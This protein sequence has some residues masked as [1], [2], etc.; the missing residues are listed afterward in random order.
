MKGDINMYIKKGCIVCL[1]FLCFGFSSS[2]DIEIPEH[3]ASYVANVSEAH[4]KIK[5]ASIDTASYKQQPSSL[6]VYFDTLNYMYENSSKSSPQN[7]L[8]KKEALADLDAM[9]DIFKNTYGNYEFFG[10]DKVF[11]NAKANII[12]E[13]SKESDITYQVFAKAIRKHLTFIDDAHVS[14]DYTQLRATP[15]LY[16]SERAMNFYKSDGKFYYDDKEIAS[17]HGDKELEHYLKPQLNN[18]GEI[19]YQFFYE[20]MNSLSEIEMMF[21]DKRIYPITLTKAAGNKPTDKA[22]DTE[23]KEGIPYVYASRMFFPNSDTKE[24]EYADTFI[25]QIT[26]IRK[27][28]VAILDLRGNTGGNNILSNETANIYTGEEVNGNM[29]SLLKLPMDD[30]RLFQPPFSWSQNI[31]DVKKEFH[32]INDLV[33]INSHNTKD[34]GFIKQDRILFVLQN[35]TTGSAAEQ[36]IDKLHNVENVVFVG[37]PSAG[38]LRGSSFLNVYLK[39]SSLQMNVGNMHT[40]FSPSYGKEYYGLEPDI[41]VNGDQALD[42]VLNLVHK[43]K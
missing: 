26:E 38:L 27:H 9:F 42:Y 1:L 28:K 31:D 40:S 35:R 5:K 24:Q 7:D 30:K 15:I 8:T 20:S 39:Y 3:V 41:W 14:I 12:E 6:D 2:K 33:Y 36:L 37:T 10:G 23:A 25:K 43:G 21:Q 16:E 29:I 17:I 22:V 18:Q 32:K 4:K 13:L 11:L 19:I 34:K